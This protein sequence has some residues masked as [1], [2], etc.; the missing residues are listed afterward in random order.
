VVAGAHLDDDNGNSSGSAYVFTSLAGQEPLPDIKANGSD[1]PL[2]VT[3]ADNLIIEVALD[4]GIYTGYPADWWV[5][6][7]TPFGWYYYDRVS[8]KPGQFVT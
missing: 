1:G 7:D 6:A 5:L 4:P 3:Q 8:W 2:T